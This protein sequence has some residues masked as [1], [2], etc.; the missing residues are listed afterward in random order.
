MGVFR[1]G[2]RL[3]MVSEVKKIFLTYL[4]QD[5]SKKSF[6]SEKSW[7]R[8]VKKIFLAP[9]TGSIRFPGGKN[10]YFIRRIKIRSHLIEIERYL[11]F[12][13]RIFGPLRVTQNGF[14]QEP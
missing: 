3:E 8:W 11:N 13:V 7:D 4:P 6:F 9:E 5:F 1:P 10:P 2:N 12:E 14:S